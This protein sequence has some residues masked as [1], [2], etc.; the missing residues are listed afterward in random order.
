MNL[1]YQE[2]LI[3]GSLAATLLVYG[4]YFA[5]SILRWRDGASSDGEVARLL[6]TAG[7]LVV[8]EVFYQ[9]LI[10][11]VEQPAPKD[12]R[13]RLVDAKACRN[14]YATLLFGVASLMTCVILVEGISNPE[15]TPVPVTPFLLAQG[16]LAAL[17]MAEAVKGITQLVYYR[18]GLS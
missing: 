9:I 4:N 16:M 6:G 18:A 2:K 1:S 10:A 7:V 13:D 8:I 3:A 17:V 11:I 15:W 14:A 12:E 5:E